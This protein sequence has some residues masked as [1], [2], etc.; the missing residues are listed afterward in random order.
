MDNIISEYQK[1]KK[2]GEQ[3]RAQARQ[4]MEGRFHEL[5][6]EAAQIGLEYHRDFGAILKP[7]SNVTAF[8]FKTGGR[9]ANKAP[10]PPAAKPAETPDPKLTGLLKRRAQIQKKIETAKVAGKPTKNL[11][12]RLYEVEDELRLSGQAV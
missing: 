6:S 7:P 1:W 8:R 3:L 12:D 2:Q 4:A 11:D 5:L 10:K 9:K